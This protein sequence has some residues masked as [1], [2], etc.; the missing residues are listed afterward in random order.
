MCDFMVYV[1]RRAKELNCPMSFKISSSQKDNACE[2]SQ[3]LVFDKKKRVLISD[4]VNQA[5]VSALEYN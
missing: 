5:V 1:W 3:S 4:I 2:I